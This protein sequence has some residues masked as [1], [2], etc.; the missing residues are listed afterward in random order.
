MM[1][2]RSPKIGNVLS[3][4]VAALLFG[5]PAHAQHFEYKEHHLGPIGLLGVTSPKDITIASV[6]VGSPAD[7]R[8]KVGDVIVGAG[9]TLFKD[10]TRKQLADAIDQAETDEG[11]GILTLTLADGRKVDLQ[12]KVLGS[13]SDTAPLNCKKTD[14]IITQT[15][16][17]LVKS[18]DFGRDDMPVGLLGLLATGEPEY[19]D[20]V[21]DVIHEA[22]W[23][24][25]DVSLT[26]ET[27]QRTA[28][29]WGYM[30]MTLAEYYL[31]TRDEYVLPAL[32]TYSVT[33][34]KGR[35]AGGLWGHGMATLDNNNG[36]WHGRLPGYSHMN[37][38]S[39]PCFI[40]VLLADK[41]GIK[42]PEIKG[43]IE[44][45][46]GFYTDFIHRGTPAYGVH[47]PKWNSYN[48]NGMSA[49]A[50]VAFSL[51][52]N[53]EGAAFFSRM[54]AAATNT[55]ETG[56]TGHY[57]NQLWTG[58]GANL[59]G[60]E[61]TAA[62]FKKTRWL[63]TLNR[64]WDG[65]F[66]YDCC[67]YKHP[68]YNYGGLSNA[69]SHLLNYCLGRRK[70]FITGRNA[71]E[72]IWLKGKEVAETIALATMDL[73]ARSD[74]ELLEF[75]GHPM[76]KVRGES[77]GA[78]SARDHKLLP[79]IR[80]ML[81]DGSQFERES[82]VSYFGNGCPEGQALAAKDE[83]A[84]IM[85]DP[86][87]DVELRAA[88][89]GTLCHL[90]EKAFPYYNGMLGVLLQ[91]KPKDPRGM[92]DLQLGNSLNVLSTNPY[93]DGLVTDKDL[94]Y[95]AVQKLLD[96]KRAQARGPGTQLI[97][98]IPLEDFHRVADKLQYL[99]D[100]KD[101]T[102]HSYHNL[103]AKTN[104][105]LIFANLRIKGGIEAAFAIFDSPLGKYGFKVK[106]LNQVVPKYGAGAK[107]FLPRLKEMNLSGTHKG[108]L[109]SFIDDIEK[110][111]GSTEVITFDQAKQAGINLKTNKTDQ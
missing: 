7:G 110:T 38:S 102:Y 4:A 9:E 29:Y 27:Y 12:L 108:G 106:L 109:D 13:Y 91:D 101:L 21:K 56:H 68:V 66:T 87:E 84:A 64:A 94:F 70:L 98:N 50:A 36:Q 33:L 89:A 18:K 8:I 72:S 67:G 90:K 86:M 42:D 81:R 32:K 20:V 74:E 40:S 65:N 54:S 80:K 6:E 103:S 78:L 48:N 92:I 58:L 44:Q 88:A 104:S 30:T 99:I 10:D 34:A 41:C 59:A 83:L 3:C 39:L 73:K 25:P 55:M 63:H 45:T 61:T 17:W 46:H 71:D 14:A 1:K 62:F 26:L 85:N 22:E 16:D 43:C 5:G 95:S 35:D 53:N 19:I 76:P 82:A 23:A 96:H 97:L 107:Y 15:A 31:L 49:L 11:K 24:K 105:L 100:D 37:Q 60:P 93:A 75:F 77:V 111:E 51:H 57:F 2:M 69:G 79:A 28:W 52:G 47:E